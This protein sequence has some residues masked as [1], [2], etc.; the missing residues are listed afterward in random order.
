NPGEYSSIQFTPRENG[1]FARVQRS[2]EPQPHVVGG[3]LLSGFVPMYTFIDIRFSAAGTHDTSRFQSLAEKEKTVI[4]VEPLSYKLAKLL[5]RGKLLHLEP[6]WVHVER[7]H[8][9]TCN[10]AHLLPRCF[11]DSPVAL[12]EA[13]FIGLRQQDRDSF[14]PG[15]AASV[16][17]GVVALD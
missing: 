14:R 8:Q 10:F 6:L 12:D 2:I 13:N 5:R 11:S 16:G 17:F 7:L 15:T 3:I 4:L 9:I 1:F